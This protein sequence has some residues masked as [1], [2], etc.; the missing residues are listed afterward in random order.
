MRTYS[1]LISCIFFFIF[2]VDIHLHFH[3]YRE[4]ALREVQALAA[5]SDT[6]H[7]V[8]YFDAWI[9]EDLLYIQL[10]YCQGCNLN[11]F[12]DKVKPNPIH[13]QTL[14][15]VLCHIAMALRDMHSRKMVHLDVKLQ[16]VLVST[17]GEIYKVSSKNKTEK[18]YPNY[19][20]YINVH[21]ISWET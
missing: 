1:F 20:L 21:L 11:Y 9:E 16:N 15:K 2:G 5:L 13:E 4:R 8:Q 14:C 17:N 10:E 18:K 6:Q 12:L 3:I 7:I 19:Q